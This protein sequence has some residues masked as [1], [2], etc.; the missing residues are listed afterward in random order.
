MSRT[1]PNPKVAPKPSFMDTAVTMEFESIQ[2]YLLENP[3]TLMTIGSMLRTGALAT[4]VDEYM[5]GK[6]DEEGP[7]PK[8]LKLTHLAPSATTFRVI[9]PPIFRQLIESFGTSICAEIEKHFADNCE[10]TDKG[11]NDELL[12]S[13]VLYAL[14]KENKS[15][16]PIEYDDWD[17]VSSFVKMAIAEYEYF[18]QRLKD[19]KADDPKQVCVCLLCHRAYHFTHTRATYDI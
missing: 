1:S 17:R 7:N 9:R 19:W 10:D 4:A 5:H 11:T 12:R 16:L 18:G 3:T 2:K 6:K 15:K 8:K 14:N 13:L